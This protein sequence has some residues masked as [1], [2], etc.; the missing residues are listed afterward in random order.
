MDNHKGG[1]M[2]NNKLRWIVIVL[3]LF[4]LYPVDA[5][6]FDLNGKKLQVMGYITQGINV[7]L[8]DEAHDT[9]DGV[10]GLLTN[11]FIEST[12]HA[13]RNTRLFLSGKATVDWIYTAKNNDSS[14]NEKGF[15]DSRDELFFDDEYWQMLNEFHLSGSHGNFFYR[16]GKQVVSWGQTD[17]VRILDLWNPV[18][19]RRGLADVEF[20]NTVIP[21]WLIRAEYYSALSSDWLDEIGVQFIINPGVDFIG[22]QPVAAGNDAGGVWAPDVTVPLG[23]TFPNDF[24]YLGSTIDDIEEPEGCDAMEFGVKLEASFYNTL[25][26][27]NGFYGRENTAVFT[28]APLGPDFS[29]ASDG[30][31]NIH[32]YQKGEYPVHKFLGFSLTRNLPF[33]SFRIPKAATFHEPILRLEA[34]YSPDRIFN[35]NDGSL[36]KLD[37]LFYG[38]SLDY[39]VKI[40]WINP[41]ST[42][43][44]TPQFFHQKINDIPESGLMSFDKED[45]NNVTLYMATSYLNAKLTPSLFYWR[46]ITNESNIYKAAVSYTVNSRMK[47]NLGCLFIDGKDGKG[48]DPFSNK[49]H[50]FASIEYRF[51]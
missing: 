18:D 28:S 17:A 2:M 27:L 33:L 14:W 6:E 30:R 36:A 39:K 11:L 31:S 13:N 49:D 16:I 23:G 29:T 43:S 48:F 51:D 38:I 7:G 45:N 41:K 1:K 24:L 25:A 37:E 15:D 9:E 35:G 8:E 21:I 26:T 12:Y 3:L 44:I 46:D 40:P 10:N 4:R 32:L 19:Q 22:N 20:E 47:L 5:K 34:T 50:V 42:V